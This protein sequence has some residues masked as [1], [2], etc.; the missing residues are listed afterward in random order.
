MW[1]LG[2]AGEYG[3]CLCWRCELVGPGDEGLRPDDRAEF[4]LGV[5][6]VACGDTGNAK[7]KT[8]SDR[9]YRIKSR[10]GSRC[11]CSRLRRLKGCGIGTDGFVGR[12]SKGYRSTGELDSSQHYRHRGESKSHAQRRL[13]KV[14]EA[15]GD[16]AC[17]PVLVQRRC[18]G[19]SWHVRARLWG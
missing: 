19:D 15:A 14:A 16:R 10:I 12:G 6:V 17:H 5:R 4:A 8:W 1:P 9:K 3:G 18:Q 11:R 2:R 7:T 13:C